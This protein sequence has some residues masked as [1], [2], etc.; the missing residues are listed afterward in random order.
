MMEELGRELK[1][2]R[3]EKGISLD[4]ISRETKIS[5]R[6]LEAIEAGD[7]DKLPGPV[8]ARA[9]LRHYAKAVGLDP[10]YV[11]E[12]YR[13]RHALQDTAP[14][15][16]GS[17]PGLSVARY[18]ERRRQRRARQRRVFSWILAVLI[19]AAVIAGAVYLVTGRR[20]G[21]LSPQEGG[22]TGIQP[23][24]SA[25]P[26]TGGAVP[27]EV[28]ALSDEPAVREDGTAIL[29]EAPAR[30]GVNVPDDAS[31]L[32]EATTGEEEAFFLHPKLPESPRLDGEELPESPGIPS[33][34]EAPSLQA[35]PQETPSLTGDRVQG[36][37]ALPA[38]ETTDESEASAALPESDEPFEPVDEVGLTPPEEQVEAPTQVVLRAEAVDECWVDVFAD[39]QRIFTG[40][41]QPG[42]IVTWVAD[43]VL[44]V[45]FGRPEVVFLTL[46]DVPLG[47][48]GTGVITREFRKDGAN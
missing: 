11:I 46:N 6:H 47:R 32:S 37:P 30:E 34:E 10:E 4:E 29:E 9:F 16:V 26:E 17:A 44:R 18:R 35:P 23:V 21:D 41:L 7:F 1:A 24:E 43:E 36:E 8:Y 15:N 3:E 27:E 13:L 12:Q 48:A 31:V 14:A 42:T 45:R 25:L 20:L 33:P 39:G 5:R 38:P 2:V 19:A 22:A 28:F 40:V